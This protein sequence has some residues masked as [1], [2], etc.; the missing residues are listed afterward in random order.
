MSLHIFILR[1]QDLGLSVNSLGPKSNSQPIG[2][3]VLNWSYDSKIDNPYSLA[4]LDHIP[5]TEAMQFRCGSKNEYQK[6]MLT[7]PP[8]KGDVMF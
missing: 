7:S 1:T 4:F 8:K 6:D 2:L 3:I 5:I